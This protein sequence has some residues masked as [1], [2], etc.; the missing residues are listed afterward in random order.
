MKRKS[1]QWWS[2]NSTNASTKRTTY[3]YQNL[4]C[5]ILHSFT[6]KTILQVEVL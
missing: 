5:N 6:N 2:S 3:F 4:Q 1:K